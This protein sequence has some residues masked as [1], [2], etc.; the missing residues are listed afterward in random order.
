ME[1]NQRIL[2]KFFRN[3]PTV[4][5]N[6]RSPLA[7]YTWTT[8][9]RY[10]KRCKNFS[11]TNIYRL[12]LTFSTQSIVSWQQYRCVC[13]EEEYWQEIMG[14]FLE[15]PVT[16]EKKKIYHL[17]NR[18][19]YEGLESFSKKWQ[20]LHINKNSCLIGKHCKL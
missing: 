20:R 7:R 2:K 9:A 13:V 15:A 19:A 4:L 1:I 17:T 10:G 14:T 8:V 16:T 3:F 5:G 18:C 11:V 6:K 12:N